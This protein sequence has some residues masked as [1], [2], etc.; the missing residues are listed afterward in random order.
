M[1]SALV[2]VAAAA[3]VRR[4]RRHHRRRRCRRHRRRY[5]PPGRPSRFALAKALTS[6]CRSPS[7]LTPSAARRLR[8]VG[9][10]V[11]STCSSASVKD[12]RHS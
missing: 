8:S 9:R 6:F 11:T 1:A 5:L 12:A 10:S 2:A 7:L 4:R 3:A